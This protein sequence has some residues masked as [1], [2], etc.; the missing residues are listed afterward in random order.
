MQAIPETTLNGLFAGL[1]FRVL[2]ENLAE[3]RSLTHEIWRTLLLAMAVALLGEALL[4]LPQRRE[5][6]SV[7]ST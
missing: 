7:V 6:S 4:C 3:G 1:D 2:T 5:P